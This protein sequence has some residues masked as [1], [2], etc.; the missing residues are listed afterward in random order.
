MATCKQRA[1]SGLPMSRPAFIPHGN[2]LPRSLAV[3]E[4]GEGRGFS[5]ARLGFGALA[6]VWFTS[7]RMLLI[8]LRFDL[9][10][11]SPWWLRR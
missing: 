11:K 10:F 4:S 9:I 3:T 1:S 5:R 2:L 6:V 8:R 7:L